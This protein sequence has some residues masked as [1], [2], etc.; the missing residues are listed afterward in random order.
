MDPGTL[1][2][3]ASIVGTI[4]QTISGVQSARQQAYNLDAEAKSERLAAEEEARRSRYENRRKIARARALGAASGVDIGS[5]SPLLSVLDSVR[6]AELEAQTLS[7]GG[8][9][10]Q[11]QKK[12]AA[13]AA[14]GQI[15]G[16]IFGGLAKT[17]GTILGDWWSKRQAPQ[18]APLPKSP[19]VGKGGIPWAGSPLTVPIA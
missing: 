12:A 17:G 6:Q 4:G 14:R 2:L 13:R 15:P 7:Y 3:T 1:A 5:G 18:P 19:K 8:Q 9:L 16:L 11:Q 10:R